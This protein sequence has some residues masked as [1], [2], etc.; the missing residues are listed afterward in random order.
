[1]GA[2]RTTFEKLQRDRAKKAKA[3]AKRARRMGLETP[4]TS[5]ER[6]DPGPDTAVGGEWDLGPSEKPLSASELLVLVE[7]LQQQFD[8][9]AISFEEYEERKADL[10]AR[11]PID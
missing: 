3:D 6:S 2:N 8:S 1:M 9:K 5:D 10:M 4:A 11:L 7:Q